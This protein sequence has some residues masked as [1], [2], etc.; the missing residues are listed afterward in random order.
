MFRTCAR[1][2]YSAGPQFPATSPHVTAVGGTSLRRSNTC[3]PI[4]DPNC[5]YFTESVWSGAGSGCSKVYLKRMWQV[6]T[7]C[8]MRMEADVSAVGD[9]S[10]GVAV[11]GPVVSSRSGWMV[12]GGTSVGAPLI[13]AIYGLNGG[14]VDYGHDPYSPTASAGDP[15]GPYATNPDL[16]VITS[17][18]NGACSGSYFCTASPSWNYNGPTGLGTPNGAGAFGKQSATAK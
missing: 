9:P 1:S 5:R 11:Y 4:G 13:A 16:N 6:D 7:A 17:G 2:G 10:T 3:V 14:L 8:S 12:F 15:P 18:N